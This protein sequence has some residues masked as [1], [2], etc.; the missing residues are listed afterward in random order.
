MEQNKELK[1]GV[2]FFDFDGTITFKD[3]FIEFIKFTFGT[4]LYLKCLLINAPFIILYF[5]GLYSNHQLKERFFGFFFKNSSEAEIKVKGGLFVKNQLLKICFPSAIKLIQWHQAQNHDIYILTASSNIWLNDWCKT[6]NLTLI[7][8][9]FE[10]INGIYTGKIAGKNC[11]GQEKANRIEDLLNQYNKNET[12]GYGN[13]K[14]DNFFLNKL[15]FKLN[16]PLNEENVI[17][18]LNLRNKGTSI[19]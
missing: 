19:N 4:V 2:A 14:A 16:A 6:N 11:H 10:T 8:T 5:L 12:Y 15:Q 13:E 1:K 7:G 17:S 18:F 3:S 9:E